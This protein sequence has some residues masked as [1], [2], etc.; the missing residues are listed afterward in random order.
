RRPSWSCQPKRFGGSGLRAKGLD[1]L[2]GRFIALNALSDRQQAGR[3]LEKLLHDLFA[4]FELD[5]RG[6]FV[7]TGEQ[8]DGSIVFDSNSYL[9][10]AKWEQG[11]VELAPLLTFREK[12]AGKSSMT[13]GIFLSVNGYTTGARDGLT[14]GRQPNFFMLDG[15]HLYATLNRE[16]DLVWLLRALRRELADK[17]R[18][19]VPLP[20]LAT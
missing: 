4:Q 8:L 2:L 13:Y 6:A 5:P 14:R 3:E 17:G 9:L 15:R 10:E 20:D 11:Q 7:V 16:V 12:V 19:Y 1:E 18:P